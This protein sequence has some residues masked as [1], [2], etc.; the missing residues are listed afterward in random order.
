MTI[1]AQPAPPEGG[2][3]RRVY[4]LLRDEISN[5]TFAIGALLPGENRLAERFD[6]SRVTVRKALD[7]LA[8]DGWIEKRLGAGSVVLDRRD[9]PGMTADLASLMPQIVEMDRATTARLLSFS[10]GPAPA[11]VAKALGLSPEAKVQTAVRVRAIGGQPF[12]HL[13]TYVPEDIAQSYDEADLAT[14]PLFRLLE[15]S[16]VQI[17]GAQQAVT[18]ALATPDVAEA[19][20]VSVGS[21]LL[22][23]KRTVW[24]SSGRAVEVLTALYRPDLFHLEMT[25][26]RVGD[27]EARH[28]E[29]VIGDPMQEAPA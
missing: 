2:K 5:G 4:L 9:T 13:T 29:P 18:A 27:G 3:T 26:T 15:R 8:R 17:D 10:Y 11:P 1:H 7:A 14:Q 6:V 20:A 19:L 12:S 16:G 25:L 21:P 22:S 28:W 23:L 24:D